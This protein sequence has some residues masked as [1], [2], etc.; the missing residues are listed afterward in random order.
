MFDLV[1]DKHFVV[2]Y[3]VYHHNLMSKT[4]KLEETKMFLKEQKVNVSIV[5]YLLAELI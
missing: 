2:Q 1:N 3:A 4:R 5:K